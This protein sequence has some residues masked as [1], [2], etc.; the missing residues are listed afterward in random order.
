MIPGKK[1]FL[2]IWNIITVNFG[3][4]DSKMGQFYSNFPHIAGTKMNFTT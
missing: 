2:V 3:Y 1:F 4:K